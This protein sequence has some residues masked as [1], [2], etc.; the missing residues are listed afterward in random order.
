M[1][2][3]IAAL[4]AS[5]ALAFGGAASAQPAWQP[6]KPVEFVVASGPGGGTD[7]FARTVQSIIAKYNLV[8]S[9]VTVSNKGGGSGAEG[10]VYTRLAE[11]DPHKIIFG[12]SNAWLLPLV[13]KVAW[14]YQDLTPIAAMAFDEFLLWVKADA[15][16]ETASDYMKAVRAAAPG[17]FRMGG[18]QSRDTDQILTRLV[19]KA[20]GVRWTYVPF[21]SGGEAGV[22]LAGG[23]IHSNTNN[24]S[25]S[26]GGWRGGQ[27]RP[28]CV[29]APQRL[30]AT[31]RV[32]E[33]MGWSDLPTCQEQG[34]NISEYRM[35]R[36]IF[37]PGNVPAGA[38]AYWEGIFRKVSETP[39]WK[40]FIE[41]TS[42]T[43]RFMPA[44]ELRGFMEQ[45]EK[46]SRELF[47]EEGWLVN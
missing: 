22:Q 26:I 30:P 45:D 47:R 46:T 32:T 24:P 13:A 1:R 11:R 29:F 21:R 42:Q 25:E 28:L 39:E 12:T 3:T 8:P 18:A 10:F 37:L 40:E 17:E 6:S 44:A 2:K 27:V 15:P 33:T 41:R 35:P 7:T 4:A 34:I 20:A 38:Q 16:Y 14:K 31:G 23:H 19:E 5:I 36:T 9:A 43:A